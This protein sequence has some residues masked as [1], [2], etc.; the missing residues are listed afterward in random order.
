MTHKKLTPK[1][2]TEKTVRD[3]EKRKML[4]EKGRKEAINFIVE[5]SIRS[6]KLLRKSKRRG[7]RS[8]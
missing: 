2:L 5:N 3:L 7:V 8:F 6:T 1:E 4:R